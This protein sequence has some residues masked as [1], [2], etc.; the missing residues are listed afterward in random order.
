MNTN[1][2]IQTL[3]EENAKLRKE[4]DK[5]IKERDDALQRLNAVY[6]I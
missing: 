5:V 6:E 2:Y 3:E 4:L 1:E